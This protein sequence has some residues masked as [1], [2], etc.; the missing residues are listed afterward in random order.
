MPSGGFRSPP[1]SGR[2]ERT[3][4]RAPVS[5]RR[6]EFHRLPGPHQFRSPE[7]PNAPL[8]L[9]QMPLHRAGGRAQPGQCLRI[10]QTGRGRTRPLPFE[11]H[12]PDPVRGSRAWSLGPLARDF[13]PPTHRP[14]GPRASPWARSNTGTHRPP[15]VPPWAPRAYGVRHSPS[16]VLRFSGTSTASSG[17]GADLSPPQTLPRVTRARPS[18]AGASS[19][20]DSASAR[21][22]C[23]HGHRTLL[24]TSEKPARLLSPAMPTSA[25]LAA[26]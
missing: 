2:R 25:P 20:C 16:A 23:R 11:R 18:P 12:Q 15:S 22:A 4:M 21:Q 5:V 17:T 3:G 10:T 6:P 24:A 8:E 7:I 1:D 19:P 13:S 14:R 9:R 26:Q